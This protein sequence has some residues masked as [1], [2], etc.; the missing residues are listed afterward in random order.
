MIDDPNRGRLLPKMPRP[1]HVKRPAGDSYMPP[2]EN[3][4]AEINV[5]LQLA[6]K[7]DDHR[8]AAGKLL[9]E[10]QERVEA[11]EAG[12]ITWSD[13]VQ[14]HIDR[15]P[16]D[17]RK[18]MA[19]ARAEDPLTA[20]SQEKER[21]RRGMAWLRHER[22]HV[23]ALPQP[24]ADETAEDLPG[25]V[26]AQWGRLCTSNRGDLLKQLWLALPLTEQSEF[27]SWLAPRAKA[28]SIRPEPG[29]SPE[30]AREPPDLATLSSP[31]DGEEPVETALHPPLLPATGEQADQS[32]HAAEEPTAAILRLPGK[33]APELTDAGTPAVQP[34]VPS[35]STTAREL[36]AIY[37]GLKPNTQKW[38]VYWIEHGH[39]EP[40]KNEPISITE[41]LLPFRNAAQ[42]VSADER[43]RFLVLCRAAE[44]A[45]GSGEQG[46]QISPPA[47]EVSHA[48]QS[49]A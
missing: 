7:A 38:A 43:D 24:C 48:Y 16:G 22:A 14:Q 3:I 39:G 11:G 47:A 29:Q 46:D 35:T 26:L 10:A 33:K 49:A 4:A 41:G 23:S 9:I 2:L 32:L 12:D 17:V 27:L 28:W 21:A 5:R 37:N 6:A 44:G 18:V 31:A 30:G 45:P 1:P 20:R 15:S 8:I 19:L 34:A 36:M 40:E 25:E 13:W 42:H